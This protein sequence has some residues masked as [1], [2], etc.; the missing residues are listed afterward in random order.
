MPFNLV[1]YIVNLNQ[2]ENI[3]D[4]NLYNKLSKPFFLTN[5]VS[6]SV[7]KSIQPTLSL[8]ISSYK[9][10]L[11]A[12]KNAT[13]ALSSLT[14]RD[15][16]PLH[17]LWC[18]Y[19][20]KLFPVVTSKPLR[21]ISSSW[22]TPEDLAKSSRMDFHG[23]FITIKASKCSTQIGKCGIV[24][25]ETSKTIVLVTPNNRVLRVV[26]K[27]TLFE[28]SLPMEGKES[29]F[30]ILIFGNRIAKL[31]AGERAVKKFKRP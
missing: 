7:N 1:E 27:G 9:S 5:T 13:K 16:E 31:S 25:Q 28:C 20:C 6:L 4:E 30:T 21:S 29:K 17:T 18:A 10:R 22:M 2:H 19:I 14:F 12:R 24:A 11:E 23:A 8:S 3:D 15:V 26:K